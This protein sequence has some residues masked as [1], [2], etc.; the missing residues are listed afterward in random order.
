M[1]PHARS[2]R[3][4]ARGDPPP[5]LRTRR[6]R[7]HRI[8]QQNSKVQ[9]L[10]KGIKERVTALSADKASMSEAQQAKAR[11][12]MQDFAAILQVWCVGCAVGVPLLLC[13]CVCVCS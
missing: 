5:R 10:A 7:R 4:H 13:I 6:R 3:P 2:R 1:T 9:G 12:L 11:K 8:T